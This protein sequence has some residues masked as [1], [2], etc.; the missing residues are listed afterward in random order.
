M[1][2]GYVDVVID[3]VDDAPAVGKPPGTEGFPMCTAK[4]EYPLVG[5]RSLFGWVQLGVR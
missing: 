2:R 5:Y 3:R 4:V 1:K